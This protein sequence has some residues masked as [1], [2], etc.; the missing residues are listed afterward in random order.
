MQR[1]P[2]GYSFRYIAMQTRASD[3]S[4][5]ERK[6][7]LTERQQQNLFNSLAAG[8]IV[9]EKNPRAYDLSFYQRDRNRLSVEILNFNK[10]FN[11]SV[12]I[13]SHI[14]KSIS[15]LFKDFYVFE[16]GN[17]V[18]KQYVDYFSQY[19]IIMSRRWFSVSWVI[20]MRR[21]NVGSMAWSKHAH[22][23]IFATMSLGI[24]NVQ[25]TSKLLWSIN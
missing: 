24:H 21:N 23:L 6:A 14:A 22:R 20:I 2:Y 12:H 19:Y 11:L 3:Y 7:T 8:N 10:T 18:A 4:L 25:A 1:R 5:F 13:Y 9:F 16:Q 17:N 15:R